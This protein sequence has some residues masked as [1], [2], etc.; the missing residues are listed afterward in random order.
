VI[1]QVARKFVIGDIAK[2]SMS[3]NTFGEAVGYV[4]QV[5]EE[6]AQNIYGYIL[7]LNSITEEEVLKLKVYLIMKLKL[8]PNTITIGVSRI[9]GA[10][11]TP[12]LVFSVHIDHGVEG[13]VYTVDNQGSLTPKGNAKY[14]REI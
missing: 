5:L 12:N 11:V 4:H 14:F 7:N 2:Y 13:I 1:T 10:D 6:E 8:E 3:F 9:K